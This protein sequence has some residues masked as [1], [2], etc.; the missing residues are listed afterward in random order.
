MSVD[1]SFRPRFKFTSNLRK[2]EI[3][4]RVVSNLKT[5]NPLRIKASVID[6]H[7]VLKMPDDKKHLW[8]P[9]MDVNLECEQNEQQTIV[10]CYIN[11]APN[12]WT[13]FMFLYALFGFI[14][15]IGLMLGLSQV[16]LNQTPYMFYL[17]LG[18]AIGSI[19]L[20]LM[21]QQG[22][23]MARDEM[24]QLKLFFDQC[25]NCDCFHI[26]EEQRKMITQ[27]A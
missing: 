19:V 17:V 26:S 23:F 22:K 9:Q 15:V 1:L 18:A 12:I 4:D 25:L 14:A 20:Y 5:S 21:A 11:P 8:S 13:L 2:T 3:V 27:E 10:R 24:I 7:I 16:T 6:Y